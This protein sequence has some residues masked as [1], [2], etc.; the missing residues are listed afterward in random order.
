MTERISTGRAALPNWPRLMSEE[1]AAAYVGVSLER[2]RIER[3]KG[4]W[5][6]PVDRGCR[7]NTYDREALDDAVDRLSGRINDPAPAIDLDQEFGL[8][9]DQNP[10]SRNA[11]A[12]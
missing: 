1:L 2:F 10:V 4:L 12:R 9:G 3:T 5:P 8:G 7:R 6:A 11:K